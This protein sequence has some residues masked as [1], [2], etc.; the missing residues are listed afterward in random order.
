MANK[1]GPR[2]PKVAG[3]PHFVRLSDDLLRRVEAH[4]LT[5]EKANKGSTKSDALRDL[6]LVGL[7]MTE[8]LW[9]EESWSVTRH[10]G[11]RADSWRVVFA[12]PEAKAREAFAGRKIGMRQGGLR[13]MKP[14]GSLD[15]EAS[16]DR[17]GA[18]ST[19]KMPNGT[20]C[21]R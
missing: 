1:R 15:V 17:G 2:R 8:R 21:P 3:E 16:M 5:M 4:R 12:G 13:L 7:R 10:G 11:R 14:N 6:V 20:E 9:P 18:I 19:A